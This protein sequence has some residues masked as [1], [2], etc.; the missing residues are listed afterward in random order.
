MLDMGHVSPPTEGVKAEK[1]N[2]NSNIIISRYVG[3][4]NL[5]LTVPLYIIPMHDHKLQIYTKHVHS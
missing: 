4:S 3:K 5:N 2:Y 1:A